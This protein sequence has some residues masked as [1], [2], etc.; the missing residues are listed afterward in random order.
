MLKTFAQNE[1]ISS[2]D[3]EEMNKQKLFDDLLHTNKKLGLVHNNRLRAVILDINAYEQL[4]NRLDELE[5]MY[6]DM[7][8]GDT[9]KERF[10]I[11][12]TE[13]IEK[14]EHVSRLSFLRQIPDQNKGPTSL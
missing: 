9:L 8:W 1:L 2:H 5:E 3:L 7:K 12:E 10:T 11:R 4:I 6:E 14:P 13:W